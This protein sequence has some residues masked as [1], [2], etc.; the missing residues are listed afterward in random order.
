MKNIVHRFDYVFLML[1][2]KVRGAFQ[3]IKNRIKTMV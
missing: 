1:E 3:L 2:Q